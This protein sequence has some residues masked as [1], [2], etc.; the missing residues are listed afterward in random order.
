MAVKKKASSGARTAG[1]CGAAC[2]ADFIVEVG[3]VNIMTHRTEWREIARYSDESIAKFV[4]LANK[5]CVCRYRKDNPPNDVNMRDT[6]SSHS[7]E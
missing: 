6:K 4:W 7:H 2:S 1:S 3:V 5:K